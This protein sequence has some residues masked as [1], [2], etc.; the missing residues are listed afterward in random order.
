MR[1]C[2]ACGSQVDDHAKF[3]PVCG[4]PMEFPQQTPTTVNAQP[5]EP[6]ITEETANARYASG[7]PGYGGY[8]PEAPAYR[9][10]MPAFGSSE[11]AKPDRGAGVR[12]AIRSSGATPLTLIL[13]IL[14]SVTLL[15]SLITLFD[16]GTMLD[17]LSGIGAISDDLGDAFEEIGD[18]AET[19]SI[20][21]IMM[22]LLISAPAILIVIGLW[23]VFGS[24]QNRG[25]NPIP[26]G[27]LTLIKVALIIKLVLFAVFGGIVLIILMRAAIAV[28]E[29]ARSYNYY[30]GYYRRSAASSAS[31]TLWLVFSMMVAVF[32]LVIVFY[33]KAIK[34]VGAAKQACFGYITGGLSM[35]V[36]VM[37]FLWAS[38]QLVA[39][40][41][42]MEANSIAYG[43]LFSTWS[44]LSQI[45][46][47][48]SY[49]ISGILLIIA[50]NRLNNAY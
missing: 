46:T 10:P 43:Y 30:G 40:F 7:D 28:R 4:A 3:C 15:I 17:T 50:K 1:F 26:S 49:I 38:V 14:L 18:I 8:R 48:A 16:R 23:V 27:G 5:P 47:I 22:G 31:G 12:E 39:F 6:P 19:G 44:I 25:R 37:C 2:S 9:A 33:A 32:V 20:L 36:A 35:Y 21:S 29:V 42:L 41:I 45:L 24:M 34:S 13:A 11:A